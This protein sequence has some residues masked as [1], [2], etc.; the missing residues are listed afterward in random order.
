[1]TQ[2]EFPTLE[3]LDYI[4]NIAIQRLKTFE[5]PD[6]YY[7]SFSGGKDSCV[8][9]DLA[10]KSQVKFDAHYSQGGLDPPELVNFIRKEHPEVIRDRPSESVWKG[11]M[12]HGM[13]RRQARWCCELIK[14]KHGTGRKVL[15]GIRWQESPRRRNRAMV[16][17]CRNDG[18]KTFI[19]PIIDWSSEEVW[20]YI[21]T[22]KVPYCSLYDEGFKR[23]GCVLCPMQT[24]KQTQIELIRFPKMAELWKRACYRYWGTSKNP[25]VKRWKSAEDMWQ[26]WLSRKG[27]P[28]VNDAQC[29]MFD[30]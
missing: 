7:L 4:T 3:K 23:L 27:E 19:H 26:W 30:N 29:I 22:N 15:T 16:E 14:E 13:P 11:L 21:K 12:K 25:G 17:T 9:L 5:P 1:M 28:K 20:D 10:V 2:P 24:P 6:G 8:L 18:T